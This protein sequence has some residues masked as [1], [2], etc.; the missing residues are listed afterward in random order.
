MFVSDYD[1]RLSLCTIQGHKL[2]AVANGASISGVGM[3]K[4]HGPILSQLAVVPEGPRDFELQRPLSGNKHVGRSLASNRTAVPR[5]RV[6]TPGNL[7]D[8][9]WLAIWPDPGFEGLEADAAA[10]NCHH[11]V[12]NVLQ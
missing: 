5:N 11:D 1:D 4:V 6:Q 8:K 3:Q 12:G 2:Q 10:V 9:L 7:G